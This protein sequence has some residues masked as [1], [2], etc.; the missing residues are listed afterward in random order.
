M[1]AN[2]KIH[3]QDIAHAIFTSPEY[4]F[5]LLYVIE[6]KQFFL[7]KDGVYE[8]IPQDGMHRIVHGY[9][10]ANHDI[11]ITTNLLQ[12]IVEQIA[13]NCPFKM[14]TVETEFVA[15]NDCLLST[16]DFKYYPFD[17]KRVALYRIPVNSNAIGSSCERWEQFLKEVLVTPKGIH[18]PDLAILVQDMFGFYLLPELYPHATFFLVGN[19]ANGKSVLLS[20][21]SA[22]IGNRYISSMSTQTL[23]TDKFSTAHLI[24]KKINICNEEESKYIRSDKFKALISGDLVM[25]ER[26]YGDHFSF[27]PQTKYIFATNEM[28]SF[29][30]LNYG[31]RRRMNIIPFYKQF[32]G[33]ERDWDL[34]EKLM[35]ELPG[36]LGWALIGAQR[37][38]ANK[39]E[40]SSAKLADRANEEFVR[41]MS[42]AIAFVKEHF[43][44]DQF[45]AYQKNQ[46][47]ADYVFWCKEVGK[48]PLSRHNFSKDINSTLPDIREIQKKIDG[49][50]IRC[51][52]IRKMTDDEY[53]EYVRDYEGIDIEVSP[54]PPILFD[55]TPTTIDQYINEQTT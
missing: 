31:L 2:K 6:W 13:L 37:L 25:A 48:K 50:N 29:E 49:V 5:T 32:K 26:K 3:N 30:G 15:L 36:I 24:G 53:A 19:G 1:P 43:V 40:F 4:A 44:V 45:G 7:Y 51:Y 52:A 9:I 38:Q 21:L 33:K 28:P 47:Y 16:K 34:T 10:T 11:N 35:H 39:Y 27:R 12:D 23:T 41:N 54:D 55:P 42:S 18:T 14:D 17:S 22:L 20:V 46:L 8:T